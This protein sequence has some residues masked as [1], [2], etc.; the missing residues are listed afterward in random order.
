MLLIIL[1]F[2]LNKVSIPLDF[3]EIS[4]FRDLDTD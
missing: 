4:L 2:L 1:F 3:R